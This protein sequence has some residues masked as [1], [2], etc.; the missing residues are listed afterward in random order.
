MQWILQL[1]L[2]S[3]GV[4]F[5]TPN[6]FLSKLW[7]SIIMLEENKREGSYGSLPH[8]PVFLASEKNFL[9]ALWTALEIHYEK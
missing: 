5:P 6:S 2:S 3:S 4:S 9:A 1:T 8:S 7:V